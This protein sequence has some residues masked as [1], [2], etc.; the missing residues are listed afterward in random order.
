M[1]FDSRG[2][3]LPR[4]FGSASIISAIICAF[5]QSAFHLQTLRA[6]SAALN[7]TDHP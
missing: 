1:G 6:N 4:C 3:E 5:S 7:L 2:S